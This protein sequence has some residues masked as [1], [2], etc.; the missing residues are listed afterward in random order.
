[1]LYHQ[2]AA[3]YQL[4]MKLQNQPFTSNFILNAPLEEF[5][6]IDTPFQCLKNPPS[7]ITAL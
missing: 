2:K 7:C 4:L 5:C 6:Q 3:G 1:M